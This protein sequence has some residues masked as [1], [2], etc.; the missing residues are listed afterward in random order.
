MESGVKTFSSEWDRLL[1]SFFKRK[2]LARQ[3][4]KLSSLLL[5]NISFSKTMWYFF[6][7]HLCAVVFWLCWHKVHNS[8]EYDINLHMLTWGFKNRAQFCFRNSMLLSRLF[9]VAAFNFFCK[10]RFIYLFIKL[11]PSNTFKEKEREEEA[12]KQKKQQQKTDSK[13][14]QNG[15]GSRYSLT[16]YSGTLRYN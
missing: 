13:T 5:D 11:R 16:N 3:D 9:V 4:Y 15:Q 1:N 7:K 10:K 2:M 12:K 8:I 6:K 14:K